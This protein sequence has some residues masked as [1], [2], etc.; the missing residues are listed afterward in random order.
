MSL[1]TTVG[2]C[3]VWLS[4]PEG[5]AAADAD[6]DNTHNRGKTGSMRFK[7]EKNKKDLAERE[8]DVA[9]KKE[10]CDAEQKANVLLERGEESET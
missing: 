4:I 3:K 9:V 6:N 2:L 1:I 8:G 7:F 5:K 10:T